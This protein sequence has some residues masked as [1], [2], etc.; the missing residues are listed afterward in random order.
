[1][2]HM[3]RSALSVLTLKPR[4]KV[5]AAVTCTYQSSYCTSS[6]CATYCTQSGLR[7]Y[8]NRIDYYRCS[9]GTYNNRYSCACYTD[10]G[11]YCA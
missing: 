7:Y 2:Q 10:A 1:M 11:G 6:R 5:A 9:D 4:A 8:T 3:L